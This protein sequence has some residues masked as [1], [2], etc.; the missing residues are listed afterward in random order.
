MKIKSIIEVIK[1][2][3]PFM[4]SICR[5][6]PFLFSDRYYLKQMFRAYEGYTPSFENP[7]SLNEKMQWL[8]LYNRQP[9]YTTMVDKIEAKDYISSIVGA[10]YII[11]TLGVWNNPDEIDFEKLP[12]QFVLKCNHNSHLGLIVCKDKATL[13]INKA[14]EELRAGLKQNFFLWAREWPYKNVKRRIL[15]EEYIENK[16]KTP[17]IDYKFYCYNGEPQYFMCSIGEADHHP[18]N[19]K[20]GMDLKSVDY[21]F[22]AKPA[23]SE[24]DVVIPDNIQEMIDVVKQLC[25]GIPHIRVDLYNVDGRIYV[26]EL[27]M[28]SNAGFYNIQSKEYSD[29]LASLIDIDA[30][31]I[32]NGK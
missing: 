31:K 13:D 15:A 11:P 20:F 32:Q 3:E 12:N 27:T 4:W 26:G 19:H 28:F 2:D 7:K 25:K 6:Y 16:K 30:I 22:K 9:I 14:K 21:L 17:L 29:Y 8:K 1:G 23:L 18:I 5:K 10:Q 24:K